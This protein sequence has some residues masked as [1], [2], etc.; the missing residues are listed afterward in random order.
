M[1]GDCSS[2]P[3][4]GTIT[5]VGDANP[6]TDIKATVELKDEP[7]AMKARRR[8][9]MDSIKD[10]ILSWNFS[11]F[12][13]EKTTEGSPLITVTIALLEVHD[14]LD[15]WKLDR[16]T[17][18]RFLRRVEAE[19]LDNPYHNAIH[20]ADV[21][22]TSAVILASLQKQLKDIPKLE[23]FSVIMA[24]AVHDLGHLGVNNDFLINSKHP[25]ATTY[26]D[27]SVNESYH[28]SRAFELA[29][30]TPG[31]DVL[32]LLSPGD[33]KQV[34]KLVVEAVMATDMA[35][36]FDLLKT[37]NMQL[38]S[39]PDLNQWTDRVL[40]Y[41]MV[42]HLA[43]IANPSRPFHLARAWAERV[44]SEFCSQGDQEAAIGL[45]VTPFCNRDTINMPK[46][47]QGFID[48]F[49]RVRIISLCCDCCMQTFMRAMSNRM[50]ALWAHALDKV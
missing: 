23:M 45:P 24:A 33:Q 28:V 10:Q 8:K 4:N 42:V 43:D 17:V 15:G 36:H 38:A 47:Q 22:Q 12:E 21:T 46:A 49:L 32:A 6:A 7:P 14:L 13:L 25:R 18:E 41:Q 5:V 2:V 27:K 20:A 16:G 40:L 31:C 3:R 1:G 39:Q 26:N 48:V 30:T 29:R 44:I 35:I 50:G 11:A 37:F 9:W 19:Y 34:R